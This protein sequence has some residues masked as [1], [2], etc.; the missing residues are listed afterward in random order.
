LF[1]LRLD[2]QPEL[3]QAAD[4]FGA[5]DRLFLPLNPCVN[6]RRLIRQNAQM[7]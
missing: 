7:N 4:G 5:G 6:S 2:S 1:G 3:D